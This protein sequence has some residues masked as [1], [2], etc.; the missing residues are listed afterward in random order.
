MTGEFTRREGMSFRR[1]PMGRFK[2]RP[3]TRKV[4]MQ[5]I[6]RMTLIGA[7]V[8]HILLALLLVY[9]VDVRN[10][11]T[12]EFFSSAATL[13][14]S[15]SASLIGSYLCIHC[16]GLKEAGCGRAQKVFME[17]DFLVLSIFFL[18]VLRGRHEHFV[19]KAIPVS[20]LCLLLG[21][22]LFILTSSDLD[23]LP[24]DDDS[25][26]VLAALCY[27]PIPWVLTSISPPP[28][29]GFRGAKCHRWS[30]RSM[31]EHR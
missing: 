31:L 18:P 8:Q 2:K 16:P 25:L 6:Q 7:H 12:A 24:Y 9:L 20:S 4:V 17:K 13:S 11:T 29:S 14:R 21:P 23:V 26:F 10:A 28:G 3:L 27:S 15:P 19:Y 1:A 5:S 22:Y 30:Y